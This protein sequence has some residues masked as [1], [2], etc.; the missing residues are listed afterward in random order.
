MFPI[1]WEW[2]ADTVAPIGKWSPEIVQFAQSYNSMNATTAKVIVNLLRNCAVYQFHDTSDT[3]D[4]KKRWDSEDNNQLRTHGGNL[5][6]VLYPGG[7]QA[8]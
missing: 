7:H 2:L 4:F 8:I 5:A 6:A 1:Q 3:S